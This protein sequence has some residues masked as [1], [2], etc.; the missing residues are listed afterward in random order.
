MNMRRFN[1]YS[2]G[3]FHV[4]EAG[5]LKTIE[6]EDSPMLGDSQLS[7]RYSP[8]SFFEPRGGCGPL[9][10]PGLSIKPLHGPLAQ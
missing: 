6:R 3:F 8:T 1:G 5:G 9:D 7:I 10:E 4:S 2:Q